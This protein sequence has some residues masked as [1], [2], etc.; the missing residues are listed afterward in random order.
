MRKRRA[1]TT[2]EL[3]LA[4]TIGIIFS[5]IVAQSVLSVSGLTSDLSKEASTEITGQSVLDLATRSLRNARPPGNCELPGST[6]T[7]RDCSR[8]VDRETAF[9]VNEPDRAVFFA[10]STGASSD[11]F[12]APD[13]VEVRV[14]KI[15]AAALEF[16]RL[17]VR[18]ITPS[19]TDDFVEAW[20]SDS[21]SLASGPGST[22][23]DDKAR[24][25]GTTS[26]KKL[27]VEPLSPKSGTAAIPLF[28]YFDASGAPVTS[29]STLSRLS[30][31]A[32]VQIQTAFQFKT[33][34]TDPLTGLRAENLRK[35]EQFVTINAKL[36]AGAGS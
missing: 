22:F 4:A 30:T 20:R 11:A 28:Q 26:V 33:S 21:L 12:A 1:F 14:E 9:L 16:S 34:K 32:M 5:L 18:T 6:S 23:F 35:Y 13:L 19:P 25:A 36:Y 15:T 24:I 2:I 17:C 7:A 31:I 27:C 8:I 10:F 29:T 3:V